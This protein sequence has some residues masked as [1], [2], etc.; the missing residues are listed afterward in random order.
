MRCNG[1]KGGQYQPLSE[2]Q[3]VNIHKAS[4]S[5]LEKVGFIVEEREAKGSCKSC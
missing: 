4:I 1:L 5:I 2:E 3:I